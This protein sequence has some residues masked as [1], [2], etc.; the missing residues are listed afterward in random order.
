MW[1]RSCKLCGK[2]AKLTPGTIMTSLV[3]AKVEGD[4][5]SLAGDKDVDDLEGEAGGG[6]PLLKAGRDKLLLCVG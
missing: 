3:L 4:K 1:T 5:A 2:M 6:H